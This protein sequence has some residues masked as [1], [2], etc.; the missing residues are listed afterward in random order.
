M[1]LVPL[2]VS[3]A[4]T[5]LTIIGEKFSEHNERLHLEL[6]SFGAGLMVGIYFLEILPQIPVG[7]HYLNHFIYL[8]FLGGFILIHI[9]EKYVYQQIV[10][11][12]KLDQSRDLFEEVGLVAYGLLIGIIIVIFFETSG[13]RAYFLLTPFFVREFSLSLYVRHIGEEL[14]SQLIRVLQHGSYVIGTIVG[15]LLIQN[16]SQLY[17]VFSLIMGLILYI[18]VRDMIPQRKEGKTVYFI[19]G[20][21]IIIVIDLL[22]WGV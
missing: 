18:V 17:F 15:L 20:V 11:Q 5:F 10:S 9:L 6:L 19:V 12:R 4:L 8:T 1:W 22:V 21:L 2:A 13:N 16:K 3:V 14:D 7:E